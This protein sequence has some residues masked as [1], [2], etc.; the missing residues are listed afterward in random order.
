MF[1]IENH[2]G[3]FRYEHFIGTGYTSPNRH[4]QIYPSKFDLLSKNKTFDGFSSPFHSSRS[5]VQNQFT[6]LF[7]MQKF[8]SNIFT[9]REIVKSSMWEYLIV[10][11]F[12]LHS[13]IL[14]AAM[15][16]LKCKNYNKYFYIFII[17]ILK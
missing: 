7:C 10:V 17:V 8:C 15:H 13:T 14:L 3:K 16:E 2:L 4:L 9:K 11:S 12:T 6:F 1:N 5:S